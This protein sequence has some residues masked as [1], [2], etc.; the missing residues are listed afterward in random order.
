MF[1]TSMVQAGALAPRGRA[2]LLTISLIAHSAVIVGAV[3][4]SIASVSF[5]VTAPDEYRDAPTF[6]PVRIPPPLGNP[7]GGAKPQVTP[8]QKPQQKPVA[9]VTAPSTVPETVTPVADAPSSSTSD[10][11]G[12]ASGTGTEPGPVGVPWGE[13]DSIGD[14]DAP[15]A[16]VQQQPVPD[17]I[18]YPPSEVKAPVLLHRVDPPYPPSMA[19]VGIPATVVVRC[20][21]DKNGS[22]R[23]AKV[24]VGAMPPF[25]QAVLDAVQQWRYSPAS[26]N[27][28]AVNTYLEVTVHFSVRR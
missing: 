8:P 16:P 9:Q 3:A 24:M 10:S 23:D 28:M 27:G 6:M 4:I 7:N 18:V 14:L 5:P 15:P 2:S 17:D 19:H 13:K 1:E 20:V 25:N 22:V 11:T 12:P 26:R 21:I